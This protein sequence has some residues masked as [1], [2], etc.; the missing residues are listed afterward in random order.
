LP[1]SATCCGLVVVLSVNVS[2]ALCGPGELGAN[3]TAMVHEPFAASITGI[4]P[5]DPPLTTNSGS[6]E[7]ALEMI[8]G[9]VLPVL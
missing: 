4:G 1:L 9:F 2:D 6:D 7:I 3:E 5:H 8:S